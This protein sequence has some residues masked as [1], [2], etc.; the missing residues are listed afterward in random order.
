VKTFIQL[1]QEVLRY[2]DLAEEDDGTPD[3]LLVQDA[4]NQANQRRASE[5]KWKFMLSTQF[6]LEV[7]SGTSEYILPHTGLDK[8]HYLY[9]T[10]NNRFASSVPMREIPNADVAFQQNTVAD[11]LYY[12]IDPSGSVVEAQ[13]S[14]ADRLVVEST[15]SEADEVGLY[16]E[17]ED[18]DGQP[19]SET[20]YPLDPPDNHG[21]VYFSKITYYAKVG[22]WTGTLSL[23]TEGGEDILTLLAAD[24]GREYAVLRFYNTPSTDETFIYRFFRRPRV[25]SRD[26]DRPDL[27]F[28]SSNLLVYDALLDLATYHELDSE[29][30]NIWRDKQQ[31]WEMQLYQFKLEGDTIA[32]VGPYIG[33]GNF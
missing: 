5:E 7:V 12:D 31:Q 9:S 21:E 8:L 33:T 27:P 1:R 13:P 26:Y 19:V 32:G 28:P 16:V 14:V 23:T 18:E 22:E 25:M 15:E 24:Y 29:S 3:V 11:N 17:G 30:V 2:F 4:L 6:T 20:I 10:T